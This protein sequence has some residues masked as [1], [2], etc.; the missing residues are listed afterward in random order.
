MLFLDVEDE[1]VLRPEVTQRA[2]ALVPFRDKIFAARIPVRV[3]SENRNLRADVMRGMQP[4]FAKN[5]RGHRGGG[6]LA[7]HARD[8]DAAFPLHDGGERF[9]AAHRGLSRLTRGRQNRVV[10]L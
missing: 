2:I 1:R 7:V 9:R 5:M 8:H 6:R 3:R 4:A 10:L